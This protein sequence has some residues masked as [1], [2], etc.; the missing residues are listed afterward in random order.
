MIARHDADV[1]DR[2]RS[3]NHLPTGRPDIRGG[4]GHV[5]GGEMDGPGSGHRP[6]PSSPI[7]AATI[8]PSRRAIV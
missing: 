4:P 1:A 7:S 3:E 6:G 2:V 8:V 5:G